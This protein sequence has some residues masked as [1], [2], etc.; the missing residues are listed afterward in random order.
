[1]V[2]LNSAVDRT[3][4]HGCHATSAPASQ[5]A[6]FRSN[7]SKAEVRSKLPKQDEKKDNDEWAR[8]EVLD[9]SLVTDYVLKQTIDGVNVLVENSDLFGYQ[10]TLE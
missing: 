6:S 7:A 9:V 3:G 10:N 2:A 4:S 5:M 1:M 8:F